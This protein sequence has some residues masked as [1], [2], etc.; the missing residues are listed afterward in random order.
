VGLHV[1]TFNVADSCITVG[2]ILLRASGFF[3]KAPAPPAP[4]VPTP[5][6]PR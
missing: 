4:E 3:V 2:A 6:A 1:P 5:D